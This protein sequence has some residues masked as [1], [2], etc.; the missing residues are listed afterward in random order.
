MRINMIFD[1]LYSGIY[2]FM[3]RI[4]YSGKYSNH[5]IGPKLHT[6][7]VT[8]FVHS[9]NLN[10]IL[11]LL[12]FLKYGKVFGWWIQFP[13]IV[14]VYLFG[15]FLQWKNG[16]IDKQITSPKS[17]TSQYSSLLLS[18]FYIVLSGY[19]FIRVGNFINTNY[20]P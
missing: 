6:F 13:I 16:R 11:D 17:E 10:T 14:T 15:Y 18:L 1:F 7:L 3:D 19:F 8:Y 2:F 4:I 12:L 5:E 9:L 20:N